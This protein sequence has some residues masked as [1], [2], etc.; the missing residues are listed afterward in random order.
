[1]NSN[2]MNSNGESSNPQTE[3]KQDNVRIYVLLEEY[4]EGP[5]HVSVCDTFNDVEVCFKVQGMLEGPAGKGSRRKSLAPKPQAVR[6]FECDRHGRGFEVDIDAVRAD[7]ARRSDEA[8]LSSEKVMRLA[9]ENP[10]DLFEAAARLS[11]CLALH[12]DDPDSRG[13]LYERIRDL[14]I[15]YGYFFVGRDRKSTVLARFA[16]AVADQ[17]AKV[18]SLRQALATHLATT[19]DNDP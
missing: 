11:L 16:A 1:M 9:R 5:S 2:G 14:M 7:T 8:S 17:I 13:K 6:L 15:A 19:A 12:T 10:D 4:A 3:S 18:P